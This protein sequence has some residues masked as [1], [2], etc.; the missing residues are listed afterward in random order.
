MVD[1]CTG[2]LTKK[3]EEVEKYFS[4][5]LCSIFWRWIRKKITSSAS[6]IHLGHPRVTVARQRAQSD[7]WATVT[8]G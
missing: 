4:N 8:L 1:N 3:Y 5:S 6:K 7:W 2:L